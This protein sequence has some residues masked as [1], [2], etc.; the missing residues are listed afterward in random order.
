MDPIAEAPGGQ[1]VDTAIDEVGSALDALQLLQL[2]RR[3]TN[4]TSFGLL[5]DVSRSRINYT[6]LSTWSGPTVLTCFSPG[7]FARCPSSFQS[8]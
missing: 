4:T 6:G 8:L 7:W 5:G 3:T 2:T 1:D